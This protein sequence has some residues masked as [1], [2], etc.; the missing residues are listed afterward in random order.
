MK[1]KEIEKKVVAYAKEKG[2]LTFKLEGSVG[3]KP[4][5]VFLKNKKAIFVEFKR[6]SGGFMSALQKQTC[7]EFEKRGFPIYYVNNAESG[8]EILNDFLL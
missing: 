4:D 6:S 5:R 8:I 2:A 7:E 3:G 1:E